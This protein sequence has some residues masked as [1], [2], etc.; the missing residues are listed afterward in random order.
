MDKRSDPQKESHTNRLIHEKSPYLLQHAHNPVDWYPWGEEAFAR[1]GEADRPVFLSIGYAT[2]HWCHVM[3]KESF[4]DPEVADFMNRVFVSIKADREERP[5]LD[6]LY[7]SVCQML[8]GSGGWPLTI[9]MTPEKRP[10][11]AGTYFSK[12]TRFGRIGLMELIPR[13]EDVWRNRRGEVLDSAERIVGTLAS[14]AEQTARRDL[15]RAT[16]DRAFQELSSSFDS[17]HGGFGGAPKFPS[18]HNLIFLMRYWKRTGDPRALQMVEKTLA[19]MRWGGLFDHV[20]LGFHRYSTDKEWLVPHFEKMLYDQAMLALAYTEAWQAAK[21]PLFRKTA[22]EIFEYVLREMTTPEGGFCAA[23]DADSEGEEGKFYVWTEEE[24]RKV[25]SRSEADRVIRACNVS[26]EGNYRDEATQKK[27]G[28]NILHLKGGTPP[29]EEEALSSALKKLLEAREKRVHPLKDDK[30]LT[31]WNGLM[32]AALARGAQV[33][34]EPRFEEAAAK[35]ASFVLEKLRT[36]EGLLHRYRDGEAAISG[37]LDDYA[38]FTWGLMELYEATLDD[39]CLSTALDLV[40]EMQVRFGDPEGGFFFAAEGSEDLI[41]RKKETQ[42]AAVPSGNSMA[43]QVLLRLGR[44]TGRMDLEEAGFRTLQALSGSVDR[45]PSAFTFLLTALDF[46]MGP[47]REIVVVG[48]PGREDTREVLGAVRH[49]YEPGKVLLFKP[50]GG[51]GSALERVA[52]FVSPY[53]TVE[54]KA[55]AY[56]CENRSCRTPLTDPEEI[57]RVMEEK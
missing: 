39:A 17:A 56:I 38:A 43:A 54:G 9:I 7:M 45:F 15:D 24:I 53:E 22:Q 29:G 25:L 5:D 37:H 44:A 50:E 40:G 13:I 20:G 46:A 51:G 55:A 49:G 27:T 16:L 42:D 36:P 48:A 57:K 14:A 1:A 6:H 47:S 18:P 10:F 52:P 11:F 3:E 26:P 12:H 31:D 23:E 2:C 33:F 35:A 4:E 30:I 32:I 19:E 41:V 8:T 34:Q 28:T 21:N